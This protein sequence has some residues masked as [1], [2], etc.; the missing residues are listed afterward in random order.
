MQKPSGSS[1][2]ARVLRDRARVAAWVAAALV[3]AGGVTSLV[4]LTVEGDGLPRASGGA[5]ARATFSPVADD[6]SDVVVAMTVRGVVA[7]VG[8]SADDLA[9]LDGLARLDR[10][11]GDDGGAEPVQRAVPQSLTI[12]AIWLSAGLLVV[13][14]A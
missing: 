14:V 4:A 9:G 3:A 7:P 11:S 8:A 10:N 6:G 2:V 1:W 12:L 5:W 13:A